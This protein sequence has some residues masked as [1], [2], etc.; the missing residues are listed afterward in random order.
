MLQYFVVFVASGVALVH[1]HYNAL[2][3]RPGN[4]LSVAQTIDGLKVDG[5]PEPQLDGNGNSPHDVE[6]EAWSDLDASGPPPDCP[7]A[8]DDNSD[9]KGGAGVS[10]PANIDWGLACEGSGGR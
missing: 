5:K 7:V 3:V 10:P 4:D 9:A 8:S 2:I 1:N 6:A